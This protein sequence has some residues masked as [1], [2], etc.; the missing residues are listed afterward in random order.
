MRKD[1][2]F[3]HLSVYLAIGYSIQICIIIRTLMQ[4][5]IANI[6]ARGGWLYPAM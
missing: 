3:R 5:A 6:A 4:K 1:E 2:D